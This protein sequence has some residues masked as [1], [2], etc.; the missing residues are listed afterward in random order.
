[1]SRPALYSIWQEPTPLKL[2]LPW[3]VQLVN[4]IA[5]FPTEEAAKRYVVALRAEQERLGRVA[6]V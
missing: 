4:Y 1:M 5:Q 6:S 3:R 2:S